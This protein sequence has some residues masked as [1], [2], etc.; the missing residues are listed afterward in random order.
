VKKVLVI[1]G[2]VVIAIA[3]V[4]AIF[5]FVVPFWA[6]S[7]Y[8]A[9]KMPMEKVEFD[10]S[11]SEPTEEIGTILMSQYLE[12]YKRHGL[13]SRLVD[14]RIEKVSVTKRNAEL[15]ELNATYSVKPLYGMHTNW[16][17]GNGTDGQNGWIEKKFGYFSFHIENEKYILTNIATGL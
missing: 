8:Y 14:Y 6:K 16:S 15:L 5:I 9:D 11:V 17:I 2:A 4:V 12:Y 13:Y 3:L 7:G 1:I 10:V